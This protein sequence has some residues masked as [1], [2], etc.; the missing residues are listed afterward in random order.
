MEMGVVKLKNKTKQ[1]TQKTSSSYYYTIKA[2]KYKETNFTMLSSSNSD[3]IF[4]FH[5]DAIYCK[6][7]M[8]KWKPAGI[9]NRKVTVCALLIYLVSDII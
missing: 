2:N 6:D 4:P 5:E 3:K 1:K 7:L 8:E 9:F